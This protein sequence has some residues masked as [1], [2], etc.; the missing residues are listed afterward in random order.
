MRRSMDVR[1]AVFPPLF[2]ERYWVTADCVT[3]RAAAA[4]FGLNPPP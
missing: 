1:A 3:L 2:R 4:S